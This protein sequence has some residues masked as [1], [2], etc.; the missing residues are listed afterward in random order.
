MQTLSFAKGHATR[1]DFVILVDRENMMPVD[2][3]TVRWLCDR[4]GGIG[5]DGVLRAVRAEH[6][7]EWQGDPGL[8]FMDYRNADG[9]VAEMCGNGL[10][11]FVRYLLDEGLLGTDA[12]RIATRAGLREAWPY[13]DRR[14]KV[15]MGTATISAEQTWIE[16]ADRRY[17]ADIVQVGNPHAV[18]H[19]DDRAELGALD[20]L[21]APTFDPAVYPSG[22]NIEFIVPAADDQ[23]A[24]RVFER[25]VGE[26]QSCG[27]GV[28]ASAVS[29]L[30][31]QGKPAGVVT[32]TV[33]GGPLRAEI[34][35]E[36]A[37]LSG[38]A[39]VVAQGRVILPDF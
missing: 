9:S 22:V 8:W 31:N 7:P 33:P 18:V 13:P 16:S 37:Y 10:R 1:N 34:S 29:H 20:L 25:G 3:R 27:T 19:L 35:P 17:R 38:P 15:S 11:L 4:R 30:R 36:Q 12:I 28:I 26:T 23:V 39:V 32:V 5:A 14:I 2:D 6:I 24:M 21:T